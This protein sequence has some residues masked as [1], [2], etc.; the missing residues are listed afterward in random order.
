M[1]FV[2]WFL[3]YGLTCFTHHTW[4]VSRIYWGPPIFLR[5]K[6]GMKI[7]F[8]AFL[9]L[10]C[11]SLVRCCWAELKYVSILGLRD[12]HSELWASQSL[13]MLRK[14]TKFPVFLVLQLAM[15]ATHTSK[16]RRS[17]RFSFITGIDCNH[18]SLI[19]QI[20]FDH[21]H[22]CRCVGWCTR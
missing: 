22:T 9:I 6:L 10:F 3:S 18:Y 21:F 13:E 20:E 1:V 11:G 12:M 5:S 4:Q 16:F 2:E 7:V 17:H 15:H 8:N 19:S 14:R